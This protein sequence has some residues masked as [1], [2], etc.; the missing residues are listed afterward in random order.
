MRNCRFPVKAGFCSSCGGRRM[1]ESAAH[2]VDDVFPT[3]GVR[4]WVLSFPMPIRF[5]LAKNPKMQARCLTIIHRAITTYIRKKA[6]KKGLRAELQPGAVTLIQRFG[7]ALNLNVHY[8]MLFLEGG[9]SPDYSRAALLV[10]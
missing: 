9:D 1:A 8:H 2:L 6:K 10:G 5:I 3:A 4:Q 7:G